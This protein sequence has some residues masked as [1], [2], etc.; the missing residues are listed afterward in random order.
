MSR[1]LSFPD[2]CKAATEG[3]RLLQQTGQ[4]S[5]PELQLKSLELLNDSVLVAYIIPFSADSIGVKVEACTVMGFIV[6]FFQDE[7]ALPSSIKNLG[8]KAFSDEGEEI[9]YVLSSLETAR[10]CS[11]GKPIEW[12][13]NSLFQDNTPEQRRARGKLLVSRIEIGLRHLISKRLETHCGANWWDQLVPKHIKDSAA[14][15]SRSEVG[16][17]VA[18]GELIDY[19]YLPHLKDL[20]LQ[21]WNDF[22]DVFQSDKKFEQALKGLNAIRRPE[23]HNRPL[24]TSQIKQLESLYEYLAGAMTSVDSETVPSFLIQNWRERLANIVQET[25]KNIPTMY[26]KDRRNSRLVRSKFD[27]YAAALEDGLTRIQSVVVPPG[28]E[29]LQS[30][31]ESHWANLFDA[32]RNMKQGA[33]EDNSL[34]VTAAAVQHEQAYDRLKKFVARYLMSELG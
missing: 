19:T 15:A 16:A 22:Q 5:P 29:D 27:R 8:I 12:L 32:V 23:A 30:E 10:F 13:T 18:S 17:G 2:L 21:H 9:M 11:E 14:N 31:L 26:E 20:V 28:K 4:I 34:T 24:S 1:E 6:G 3:F 33:D 25:A 7:F